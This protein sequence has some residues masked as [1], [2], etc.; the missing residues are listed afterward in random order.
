MS[1]QSQFKK[2]VDEHQALMNERFEDAFNRTVVLKSLDLVAIE[3]LRLGIPG[4]ENMKLGE[5]RIEI[6]TRQ[7]AEKK[8]KAVK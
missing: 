2:Q 6:K 4:W 1:E 8:E 7:D 3:A 5:L